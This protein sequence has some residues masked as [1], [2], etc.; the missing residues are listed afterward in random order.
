MK[1][2]PIE[3]AP[4]DGTRVLGF[5]CKGGEIVWAGPVRF[6]GTDGKPVADP[7]RGYW[8]IRQLDD[9]VCAVG[10]NGWCKLPD[11]L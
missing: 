1:I 5:Y 8:W 9:T 4:K 7:A 10:P 3:T 6:A 2:D 11:P